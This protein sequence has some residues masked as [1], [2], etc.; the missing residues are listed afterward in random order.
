MDRPAIDGLA[1]GPR[2]ATTAPGPLPATIAWRAVGRC[3]VTS[4]AMLARRRLWQPA[5]Q[6]G[7]SFRFADGT[8]ARVYRE[9]RVDRTPP[10]DPCVLLVT[11]RLRRVRG[12]G[13]VAFEWESVLNTVLFAGFPGLVSK[14]WLGHDERDRYR[15]LYEWDGPHLADTYARTLWRVLA[16]VS[17][18]GSIDF[19]VLPG[20]RRDDLLAD[21]VRSL[22]ATA[23]PDPWWR[24]AASS[25]PPTAP[26]RLSVVRDGS[27]RAA[28]G[29]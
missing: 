19:R 11:F 4:A 22:G 21:P 17:E 12:A 29:C 9:T 20:M 6:V 14:L 23:D 15:G 2:P 25:P 16:L 7:R 28:R 27:R 24:V 26:A 5:E 10:T 13:H 8:S 1:A 3:V 18:R